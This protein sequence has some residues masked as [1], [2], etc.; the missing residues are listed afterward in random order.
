M[1]QRCEQ[2]QW[3]SR[4]NVSHTFFGCGR[5]AED[6]RALASSVDI[7]SPDTIV[8]FMLSSEDVSRVVPSYVYVV[9]S[10]K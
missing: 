7:V 9:F 1:T 10:V 3:G 5:F 2:E 8:E 4:I 6:S